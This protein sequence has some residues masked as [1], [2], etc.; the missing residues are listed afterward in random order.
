ME[1]INLED[2]LQVVKTAAGKGNAIA[3]YRRS[4]GKPKS[5]QKSTSIRNSA[6]EGPPDKTQAHIQR[7]GKEGRMVGR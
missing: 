2:H 6:Y 4:L 7:V 5:K 1:K 3:S